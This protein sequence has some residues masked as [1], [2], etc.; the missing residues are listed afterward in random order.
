MANL[1]PFFPP[2]CLEAFS[3]HFP[4]CGDP[5]YIF[6]CQSAVWVNLNSENTIK[7][8][9]LAQKSHGFKNVKIGKN[10]VKHFRKEKIKKIIITFSAHRFGQK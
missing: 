4:P 9:K 5:F 10:C 1:I 3:S 2:I 6:H 8:G 7:M